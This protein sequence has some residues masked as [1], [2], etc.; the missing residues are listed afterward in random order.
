MTWPRTQTL[1][2]AGEWI[3]VTHAAAESAARDERRKRGGQGVEARFAVDEA[4]EHRVL[5]QGERE[6]EPAAMRETSAG[7]GTHAADLRRAIRQP[8]HVKIASER[9][10]NV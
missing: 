8:T 6:L 1:Y 5:Q 7:Q 9:Q 10:R 3:S 4:I 2:M